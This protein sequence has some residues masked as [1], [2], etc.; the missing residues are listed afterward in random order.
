[1]EGKCKKQW[2]VA[3]VLYSFNY[4]V[5]FPLKKF[6]G[7]EGSPERGPEWSSEGGSRFCLH[8]VN[9]SHLLYQQCKVSIPDLVSCSEAYNKKPNNGKSN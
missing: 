2:Y 5:F 1:M 7:P 3:H 9:M 4:T 8:P 6:R